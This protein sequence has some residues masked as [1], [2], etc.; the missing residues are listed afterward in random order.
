MKNYFII[1][2]LT[3]SLQKIS[4]TKNAKSASK[5]KFQELRIFNGNKTY[6]NNLFNLIKNQTIKNQVSISLIFTFKYLYELLIIKGIEENFHEY[7]YDNNYEIFSTV[8]IQQIIETFGLTMD[9][10]NNIEKFYMINGILE[11]ISN[12][13]IVNKIKIY[14]E[15]FE[16]T[17]F[18]STIQSTEQK[19]LLLNVINKKIDLNNLNSNELIYCLIL[20]LYIAGQ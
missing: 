10:N 1:L 20:F 18:E 7:N 5:F 13:D 4:I 12:K 11:L 15:K 8:S 14:I 6:I 3:I 17:P 9:N 19:N 16:E 2:T